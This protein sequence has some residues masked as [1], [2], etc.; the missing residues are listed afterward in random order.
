[1]SAH[2]LTW[3]WEKD[4]QWPATVNTCKGHIW[5]TPASSAWSFSIRWSCKHLICAFVFLKVWRLQQPTDVVVVCS[6]LSFPECLSLP[7]RKLSVQPHHDTF[8][9]TAC[10][11]FC[12]QLLNISAKWG[13]FWCLILCFLGEEINWLWKYA[14]FS[15]KSRVVW[16]VCFSVYWHKPDS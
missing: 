7:I 2:I 4:G 14:S 10:P 15:A 16:L 1:M 5:K 6:F 11:A 8:S 12:V 9:S 13:S 3:L